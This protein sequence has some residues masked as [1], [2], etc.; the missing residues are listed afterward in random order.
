MKTLELNAYGVSEMNRQEMVETDGGLGGLIVL[1]IIVVAAI[2]SGCTTNIDNSKTVN[3]N[4]QVN[5]DST[6]NQQQGGGGA[7]K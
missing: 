2:V 7:G 6:S 3:F 1:G 4:V 5:N